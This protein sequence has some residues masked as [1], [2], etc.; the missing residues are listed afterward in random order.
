MPKK[1]EQRAVDA[2]GLP[3]ISVTML[4]RRGKPGEKV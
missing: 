2:K 3:K 1:K 4:P